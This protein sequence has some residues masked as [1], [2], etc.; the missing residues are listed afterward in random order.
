MHPSTAWAF[1]QPSPIIVFFTWLLIGDIRLVLPIIITIRKMI[2]IKI[3]VLILMTTI[4]ILIIM[5]ILL[6]A[7]DIV[8]T[9]S[10]PSCALDFIDFIGFHWPER[11]KVIVDW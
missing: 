2:I 6:I 1:L 3:I 10:R 9:C 7:S 11:I 8:A 5:Q 4:M